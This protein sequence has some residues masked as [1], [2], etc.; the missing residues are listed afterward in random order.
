MKVF[1]AFDKF[2]HF[3]LQKSGNHY[4]PTGSSGEPVMRLDPSLVVKI[5]NVNTNTNGTTSETKK[6]L[7]FPN[8]KGKISHLHFLPPLPPFPMFC[9]YPLSYMSVP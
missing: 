6:F 4:T 1:Q 9:K 3:T 8:G 2:G 5:N 7:L